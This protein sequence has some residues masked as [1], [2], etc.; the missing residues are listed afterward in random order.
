[1]N[2]ETPER[3]YYPISNDKMF[4]A[5]LASNPDLAQQMIETILDIRI[6]HVV[7]VNAQQI[8]NYNANVKSVRFDVY[9]K[10]Q[11]GVIYDVEM[12]AS[13]KNRRWLP[14]RSRY[15]GS[16]IDAE[17]VKS[18]T[19]YKDIKNTYIIFICTY[20][21]FDE[22]LARYTGKTMCVEDRGVTME[23]GITHIYLNARAVRKN[24]SEEL[25]VLLDYIAGKEEKSS[26]LTDALQREVNRYNKDEDWRHW[27]M[28]FEEELNE[29]REEG[30]EEGWKEGRKVG[31]QEMMEII[32]FAFAMFRYG[33]SDE[34]LFRTE[35]F[36]SMEQIRELRKKWRDSCV[37][38]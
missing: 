37:A 13:P 24:V 1:M 34:E 31:G 28:T 14:K 20:D 22:G 11:A 23:D 33:K 4:A 3:K 27:S 30:R 18:G 15:Y 35:R 12:Q 10:D 36:S 7:C 19:S 38:A 6:D 29:A 16:V 9:I 25:A 32:F 5:V 21:P 17:T 26:E 8:L 2:S